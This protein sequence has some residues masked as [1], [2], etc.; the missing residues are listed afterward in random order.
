MQTNI[1]T[2]F[3][4][5][6]TVKVQLTDHGRNIMAN[7]NPQWKERF[8]ED[9]DGF[10]AWLVWELMSIFGPHLKVGSEWPFAP[11]MLLLPPD[12]L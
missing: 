7:L 10:S 8:P 5:H 2:P 11:D 1:S 4:V 3:S 9:E 12:K 6:N